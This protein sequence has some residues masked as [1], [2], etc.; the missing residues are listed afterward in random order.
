MASPAVAGVAA[1]YLGANG[2]KTPSEVR[3]AIQKQALNGI[4]DNNCADTFYPEI[5]EKTPN[6]HVYVPCE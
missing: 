2:P 5:C 4:V 1:L 6:L 3:E